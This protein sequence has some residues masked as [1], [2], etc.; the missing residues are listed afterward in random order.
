MGRTSAPPAPL[1][2]SGPVSPAAR[3]RCPGAA[4]PR[5]PAGRWRAGPRGAAGARVHGVLDAIEGDLRL[6]EAQ[7]LALVEVDG[8]GQGE[9]QQRGGPR[10]AGAQAQVGGG[11]EALVGE[12]E[13]GLGAAVAGDRSGHVVVAQHPGGGRAHGGVL[14]QGVPDGGAQARR[15]PGRGEE[16]EVEGG[17]QLVPVQIGVR[18][19]VRCDVGQLGVLREQ[20]RRVDAQGRAALP[21]RTGAARNHECWS[22]T[23]LGTMSTMTRNVKNTTSTF[24]ITRE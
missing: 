9:R 1:F 15:V 22:D 18:G 6:G 2:R 5:R 7:L 20:R 8:A 12:G 4:A 17:V 10:A 19:A 16:G 13:T 3:P 11:A 21:V 24:K 14:G 23:W